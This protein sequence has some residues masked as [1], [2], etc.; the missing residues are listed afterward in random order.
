MKRKKMITILVYQ[1]RNII[2]SVARGGQGGQ[3]PP[4]PPHN[5]FSEFCRYIWKFV[6]TC[7]PTSMLFAPTKYQQNIERNSSFRM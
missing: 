6:G 3:L 2:I 7:K 1:D 4:P 5:A